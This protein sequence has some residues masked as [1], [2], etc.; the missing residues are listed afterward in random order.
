MNIS[1]IRLFVFLCALLFGYSSMAETV[2]KH[3]PVK[4]ANSGERIPI[5]AQITDVSEPAK[6]I[7]LVRVYF[8]ADSGEIKHFVPLNETEKGN[9]FSGLLPAPDV[10]TESVTYQ[11]LVVNDADEIQKSEELTIDIEADEEAAARLTSKEPTD[12]HVDVSLLEVF[13]EYAPGIDQAQISG[14]QNY[15]VNYVSPGQAY[16]VTGQVVEPGSSVSSSSA[17]AS[18]PGTFSGLVATT[19]ADDGVS[20]GV[21][22]LAGAAVA[23]GAGALGSD[24]E[25]SYGAPPPTPPT[26]TPPTPPTPTPPTPTP[27]TP[28]PPTPTPPTPPTPT[29]PTPT[30]PTPPTPTPP[31]T[32]PTP[33]CADAR[34]AG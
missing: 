7:R 28:T 32:P 14:F 33:T 27:P 8:S 26:P 19:G 2:I 5:E 21:V 10:H 16:G 20:V 6:S 15:T 3:K 31:P 18:S 24:A 12:L 4:S 1:L 30:P 9:Q 17:G 11:I 23:V 13:S 25:E 29:P 22:A 34:N